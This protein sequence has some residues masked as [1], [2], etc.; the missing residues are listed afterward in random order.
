MEGIR[1]GHEA[2]SIDGNKSPVTALNASAARHRR[3][4]L[5]V[6]VVVVSDSSAEGERLSS[7][8][9]RGGH[10]VTSFADID[11]A[12]DSIVDSTPQV[13]LVSLSDS[14]ES[15]HVVKQAMVLQAGEPK[16]SLFLSVARGE[17]PMANVS[18][19][20][21]PPSSESLL[22]ALESLLLTSSPGPA[23]REDLVNG[24]DLSY[25]METDH[26]IDVAKNLGTAFLGEYVEMSFKDIRKQMVALEILA[27]R[28]DVMK[29]RGAFHTLQGLA[30]NAGCVGFS[31][32]VSSWSQV[33][34][35]I[36]ISSFRSIL[37]SLLYAEPDARAN[38]LAV[39]RRMSGGAT[40][41][42]GQ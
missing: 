25:A 23:A 28:P 22:D 9:R 12:L 8:L 31:N 18:V 4:V 1:V 17:S 39:V 37:Q 13:I 14:V 10:R 41:G 21:S 33:P 16:K 30:M 6:S 34:D 15:D 11:V 5:S 32:Y 20:E 2:M 24:Y 3:D 27:F 19:V 36:V 38:A 26:L 29:I 35:K 40:A 7:I 42:S